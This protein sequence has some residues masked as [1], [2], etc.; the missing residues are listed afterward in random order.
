[1]GNT[2]FSYPNE[3]V[4]VMFS[5]HIRYTMFMIHEDLSIFYRYSKRSHE[6][7]IDVF[8]GS[9]EGLLLALLD[10]WQ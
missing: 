2:F 9:L 5:L 1:M 6:K 7:L 8:I 3:I 4:V 10:M